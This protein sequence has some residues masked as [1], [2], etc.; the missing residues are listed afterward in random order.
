MTDKI[1]LG[2][3]IIVNE[4]SDYYADYKNEMWYVIGLALEPHGRINVTIAQRG[5]FRWENETDG[6]RPEELTIVED[7]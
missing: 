2:V 4:N 1:K 6:F 5:N 3:E 7:F